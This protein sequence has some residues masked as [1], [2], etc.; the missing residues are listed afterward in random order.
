MRYNELLLEYSVNLDGYGAWYNP[1]TK[2]NI[3]VF[4]TQGHMKAVLQNYQEFG[5]E[6]EP[7]PSRNALYDVP[8]TRGWVRIIRYNTHAFGFEGD[9]DPV[10]RTLLLL[11]QQ[12]K[13]C[14][15]SAEYFLGSDNLLLLSEGRYSDIIKEIVK[16]MKKYSDGE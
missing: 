3:P 10:Y 9:V 11:R 8:F 1:Q 2:T 15:I 4:D 13:D 7:P 6:Q 12:L 14:T 5:F 16:N